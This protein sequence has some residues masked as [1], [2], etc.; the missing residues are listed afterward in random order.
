MSYSP[1]FLHD[2]FISY[3]S[4]DEAPDGLIS[5]FANLLEK[6]L[7]G[8]G[9]RD[10]VSIFLDKTRL[11]SGGSLNKQIL[12]GAKSTAVMV[13]FH[14]PAYDAS[15]DWCHR[16]Y[17]EF[18][19]SNPNTEGRFFLVALEGGNLPS[20]SPVFERANRH[21]RSFFTE[22]NGR[23]FR[24][25]PSKSDYVNSESF[26]L[27]EEIEILAEEIAR[28][29][30]RLRDDSS[31]KRVF[32]TCSSTFEAQAKNL[33]DSLT[34]AD[35][36]VL[37][38]SPWLEKETRLSAASARIDRADLVIGIAENLASAP[39][40][41]PGTHAA[42][43]IEIATRLR[44]P[45]L[46]WLPSENHGFS[47]DE[48]IALKTKP[49][50]IATSLEEFKKIVS[51]RLTGPTAPPPPPSPLGGGVP[52]PPISSGG[53]AAAPPIPSGGDPTASAPPLVLFISATED[54][55]G[56]F[57]NL[58]DR[59]NAMSIGLDGR[60]DASVSNDPAA[61]EMWCRQ[62][63]E[64]VG[65]FHHTAVVFVDGL[66]PREWIDTR[67]RNYLVL[68]RDLAS[69]PKAAVCD[70]PPLPKDKKR[71]FRPTGRVT[72]L[73]GDDDAALRDFLLK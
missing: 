2:I 47:D 46:L 68:E 73:R 10:G 24:F 22:K 20:A 29:L 30:K 50:V 67:L 62:I 58:L 45:R 23:W 8:K 13:A 11:D 64:S 3:A 61:I 19:Q 28:T 52:A 12:A 40:S 56:A 57:E 71:Q 32:L 53:D 25:S 39:L 14:S 21:F 26:T 41:E 4:A 1:D 15:E 54:E 37:E 72:F 35:F 27:A 70:F 18:I 48:L 38:S 65:N 34:D 16:E 7:Q 17:R 5:S 43:Q 55:D 59:V 6:K 42:E 36:I 31:K 63:K 9:V 51:A 44:K 33:Q 60:V 69:T 66:C 49:D